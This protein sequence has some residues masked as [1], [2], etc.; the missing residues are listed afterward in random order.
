M[1]IGEVLMVKIR[2]EGILV[3]TTKTMEEITSNGIQAVVGLM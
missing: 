1:E 2:E 3:A